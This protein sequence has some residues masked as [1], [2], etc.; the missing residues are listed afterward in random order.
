MQRRSFLSLVGFKIL[1][2]CVCWRYLYMKE[3]RQMGK[4]TISLAIWKD[5]SLFL[6]TPHDKAWANSYAHVRLVE[7]VGGRWEVCG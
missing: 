6:Y 2:E 1:G 4:R 3:D 7:F 5:R